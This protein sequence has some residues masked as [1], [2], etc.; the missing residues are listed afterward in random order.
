MRVSRIPQIV[1][2]FICLR[3]PSGGLLSLLMVAEYL[4]S[5]PY[6]ILSLSPQEPNAAETTAFRHVLPSEAP[7]ATRTTQCYQVI[8]RFMTKSFHRRSQP[9]IIIFD[10]KSLSSIKSHSC[11]Y[12]MNPSPPPRRRRRRLSSQVALRGSRS[13]QGRAA[14]NIK[15]SRTSCCTRRHPREARPLSLEQPTIPG[16][17]ARRAACCKA[18]LASS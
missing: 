7:E 8:P 1:Y 6:I 14:E 13:V 17:V 15:P 11:P 10:N 12:A 5:M 3:S 18:L 16:G 2:K 4:Y 9:T